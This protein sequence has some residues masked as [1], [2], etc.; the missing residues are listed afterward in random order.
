MYARTGTRAEHGFPPADP[1][2]FH[3]SCHFLADDFW[4]CY[5]QAKRDGVFYF[6]G[7]SYEMIHE[8]MW[9]DFEAKIARISADPD[10]VWADVV[11]LFDAG[12]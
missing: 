5:G 1:M 10:V 11:D 9:A 4:S 3:P 6:W 2:A 12:S 7:H 8:T